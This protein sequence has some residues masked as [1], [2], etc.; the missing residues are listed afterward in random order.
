MPDLPAADHHRVLLVISGV[1]SFGVILWIVCRPWDLENAFLIGAH[2]GRDF[3][4]FWLGGRLAI[5]GNLDLL[6][7]VAAYNE[8]FSKTFQHNPA[9]GFVYSYPPH[10]LLLVAPFAALPFVPA[11]YLWTAVNLL[12]IARSVQLLRDDWTLATTA[13]LSPAVLTMAIFGHFGGLLAILATFVLAHS[14]QRPAASG[15]CLAL[16]SIKP[17]FALMAGIL[18]LLSGRWRVVLWS[19]P[20]TLAL[21]ALSVAVF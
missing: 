9:E 19:I 5:T 8:L 4:N 3:A 18:L 10:S 7:D 14:T 11:V 2:V 16:A 15:A 21:V 12:C 17:Q 13:C 20:A 1:A 6:I